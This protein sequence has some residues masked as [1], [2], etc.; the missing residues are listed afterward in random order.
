MKTHM[1]SDFTPD[2]TFCSRL[3]AE[4]QLQFP[5]PNIKN[6]GALLAVEDW[7]KVDCVACLKRSPLAFFTM[8][9]LKIYTIGVNRIRKDMARYADCL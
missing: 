5:F 7:N 9:F 8:R 2:M 3:V 4:N 1:I 6:R